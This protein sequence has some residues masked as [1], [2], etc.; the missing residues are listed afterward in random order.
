MKHV[1][2]HTAL[3]ACLFAA[4]ASAASGFE[5][6]EN[7]RFGYKIDLPSDFKKVR[8]PDNG[9]GIGLES[10]DGAA[11]LSVWGN[12]IMEG[13]FE[14]E[15]D[16]RRKLQAQEGWKFSYEKR[17]SSWASFSGTRGDRIIYM[18]EIALCNEAMGSF[19]IKY[20][21]SQ[22]TRFGPVIDRLVKSLKAPQQCE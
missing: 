7:G 1:S 18:R 22:R 4:S 11:T 8:I 6:Y 16:L 14:A 17:G 19:T 20:P 21:A 9:D 5:P 12:H 10:A 3:F 2:W 15:S 13:G